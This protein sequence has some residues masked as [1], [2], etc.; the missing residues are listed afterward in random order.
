MNT[1]KRIKFYNPKVSIIEKKLGISGDYQYK[2][3]RSSN[4]FQSNWHK[5]KLTVLAKFLKFEKTMKILNLGTGSGNFEIFAHKKVKLIVG[6]DY[7]NLALEFIDEYLQEKKIKNVELIQSDIRK[8]DLLKLPK[9]DCI[10]LIDV[11]EHLEMSDVKKLVF[12]LKKLLKPKG[13]I[14]VITPNYYSP[15]SFMEFLFDHALTFLLPKF[16]QCQ[17]LSKFNPNNLKKVFEQ[18]GFSTVHLKSF[19][20]FSWLVPQKI[21]PK[22]LHAELNSTLYVGNL[23]FGV[24]DYH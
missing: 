5:N 9:F 17:H 6:I 24:F 19:N 11:I 3:L 4:I 18:E 23:L 20:L 22:V 21:A 13:K 8:V 12:N 10:V 15:W 14:Y 2:A 1:T 7:N 16:G